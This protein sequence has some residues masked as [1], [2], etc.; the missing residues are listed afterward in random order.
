M[1]FLVVRLL[2]FPRNIH[3]MSSK[4]SPRLKARRTSEGC[5]ADD[6]ISAR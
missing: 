4:R 2:P 6:V 5:G 1:L 3:E